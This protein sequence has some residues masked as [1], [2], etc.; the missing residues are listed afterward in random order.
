MRASTLL[1]FI[2]VALVLIVIVGLSWAIVEQG[3][4][5]RESPKPPKR[6]AVEGHDF[7]IIGSGHATNY[8]HS[9]E[10]QNPKCAKP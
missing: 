7:W 9:P 10:C 5:F 1:P 4:R 2:A 6:L 3:Q 8:V